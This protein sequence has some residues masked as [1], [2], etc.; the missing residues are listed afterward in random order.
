MS[1]TGGKIPDENS[2]EKYGG[3]E[4]VQARGLESAMNQREGVKM[5]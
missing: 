5:A 2:D 4:G 1:M 3:R